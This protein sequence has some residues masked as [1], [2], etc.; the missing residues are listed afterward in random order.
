M[1][2]RRCT[3]E[4]EEGGVD[5]CVVGGEGVRLADRCSCVW[6]WV[7]AMVISTFLINHYL[8]YSAS[9]PQRSCMHKYSIYLHAASFRITISL[10]YS[11]TQITQ[12]LTHS[13]TYS[14][15]LSHPVTHHSLTCSL[16]NSLT[17][18]FSSSHSVQ[19]ISIVKSEK[20][21]NRSPMYTYQLGV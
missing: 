9:F 2:L 7:G 13:L 15:I 5:R 21:L 6:Y 20:W 12:L 16:T 3:E 8:L 18:S 14:H 17:H 1:V 4:E 11:V 19:T 10:T